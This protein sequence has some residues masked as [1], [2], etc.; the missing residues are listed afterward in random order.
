MGKFKVKARWEILR[1]FRN[2]LREEDITF[3]GFLIVELQF[4][5]RCHSL[6]DSIFLDAFQGSV[7]LIFRN[8]MVVYIS[9]SAN[10]FS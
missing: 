1:Q 9:Q 6:R 4:S 7:K 10:W 3:R 2:Y 8:S 5:Y